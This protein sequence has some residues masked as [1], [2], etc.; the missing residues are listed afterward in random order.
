MFFSVVITVYEQDQIFLPRAMTG[1]MNQSFRD[2][3]VIVIVDGEAP[4]QPY[5]PRRVC[6]KTVPVE[7]VYRPRSNTIGFRERH[8]SLGL[9]KGEYIVW[10][11]VDNLIYPNWLQNH[12][13]NFGESPGAISVVNIQYWLK[14]DYWGVLPRGLVYGEMDLLNYALPLELAR[15]LNVFGPDVEHTPHADWIA[16]ERCSQRAPVVW[17]KEQPIC[18][19]HF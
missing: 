1:L 17:H 6:H 13:D 12:H 7:I 16:F 5:D 15:R 10:L 9:A 14:Q 8:H 3:E 19:C 18:A 11:N 4:L 2:F